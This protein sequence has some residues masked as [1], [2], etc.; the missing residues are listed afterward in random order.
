MARAP[1]K[2]SEQARTADALVRVRFLS[3]RTV[4]DHNG[5]IEQAFEAGKVYPLSKASADRWISR[6]AA[7]IVV[8]DAPASPPPAPPSVPAEKEG[9]PADAG[10]D[11]DSKSRAA[12]DRA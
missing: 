1:R 5:E 11:K 6:G 12:G 7:E 2:E 8:D 10:P 9:N 4:F 3:A